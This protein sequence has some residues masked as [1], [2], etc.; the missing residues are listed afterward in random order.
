MTP[1]HDAKTSASTKKGKITTMTNRTSN[2][3]PGLTT[4]N[5]DFLEKT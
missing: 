3:S 1:N 4:K 5:F 2:Q